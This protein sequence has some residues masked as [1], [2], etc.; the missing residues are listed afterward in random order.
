MGEDGLRVQRELAH[1]LNLSVPL[2][3]WHTQRDGL[4][5]FANWLVLLTGSL[6]KMATDIIL[7]A[8]NEVG[9]VVEGGDP[10]RGGS[11]T[12]PQKRNP[13]TSEAIVAI[14]RMTS[15]HLSTL[16]GALLH[17]HERA[18]DSWQAEW[19]IPGHAFKDRGCAGKSWL[20]G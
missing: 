10:A 15:G 7:L 14:H 3:T 18:T 6:A 9:E 5:E 19:Y 2:T 4:V 13:M 12:M 20:A 16:H 11:S 17:Q 8:Q 1:R